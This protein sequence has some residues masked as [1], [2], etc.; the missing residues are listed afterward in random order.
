MRLERGA[1]QAQYAPAPAPVVYA[2]EPQYAQPTSSLA[3]YT[4]PAVTIEQGPPVTTMSAPVTY[5]SAPAAMEPMTTYGAPVTYA[6]EPGP[7]TYAAP[8]APAPAQ[9]YQPAPAVT[10][11]APP[12]TYA[13][14]TAAVP[15]YAA[16]P[17]HTIYG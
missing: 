11:A 12:T 17:P 1:P 14:P 13:V 9:Y 3:G 6:A 4:Q 2:A 15:Q 8:P 10:Y 16:A 5:A 7:I